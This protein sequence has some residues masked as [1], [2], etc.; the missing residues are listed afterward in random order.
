MP[1]DRR[2]ERFLFIAV[3]I[4]EAFF[5]DPQHLLMA[6]NKAGLADRWPVR[7]RRMRIDDA[8]RFPDQRAHL[9]A[10]LIVS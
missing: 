7:A 2:Q 1:F 5:V 10:G 3:R 9:V 6:G 4:M 8:P